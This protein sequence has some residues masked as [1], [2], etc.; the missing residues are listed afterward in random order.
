MFTRLVI[1]KYTLN[2]WRNLPEGEKKQIP[3]NDAHR[4]NS[5]LKNSTKQLRNW[6][7][8]MQEP[9]R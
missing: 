2:E 1:S 9:R 6:K 5:H 8:K 4:M 3:S 7:K